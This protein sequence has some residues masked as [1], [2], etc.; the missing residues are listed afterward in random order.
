MFSVSLNF[1]DAF[2]VKEANHFIVCHQVKILSFCLGKKETIVRIF[3]LF[4]FA[5]P[6][7]G[8]LDSQML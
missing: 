5:S 4:T 3:V 2:F 7:K 6:F 1:Q 8:V